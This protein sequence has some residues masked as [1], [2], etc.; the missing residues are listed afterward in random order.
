MVQKLTRQ[1]F[2]Q[3]LCS[4]VASDSAIVG[5]LDYGSSSEGRADQWSDVDVALFIRDE[6][7][8][9]FGHSWKSWAASLGEL[10]WAYLHEPGHPWAIYN[11]SPAP[12]RVDF[13]LHP[14]SNAAT[15][16]TWST[17]PLSVEAMVLY[18]ASAGEISGYVAQ[19]VGKSKQVEATPELYEHLCGDFWD[20]LLMAYSKYQRDQEWVA[21]FMYQI[22]L[23]SLLRLLRIETGDLSRL[24]STAGGWNVMQIITPT[25]Q[26]QLKACVAGSNLISAFQA[27]ALLGREVCVAVG[28]IYG[29]QTPQKLAD[30]V[31][32]L[33]SR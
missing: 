7:L 18:D 30:H 16:L 22:A 17:A 23:E 8:S 20:Y 3:N 1:E 4:V 9:D 12:L 11:G 13:A 31:V 28:A 29:W 32:E 6:A 2:L 10:L 15:I 5:L 19:L 25:R 33:V 27:A 14:L 24:D 21:R 26:A